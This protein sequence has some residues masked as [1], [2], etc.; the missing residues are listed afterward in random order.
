MLLG[1]AGFV[2]PRDLGQWTLS[3]TRLHFVF[4]GFLL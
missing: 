4:W 1:N 2:G 3:N